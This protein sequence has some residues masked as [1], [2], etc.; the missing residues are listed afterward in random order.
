MSKALDPAV[1]DWA[2]Y[3]ERYRK[4]ELRA[5][6]FRDVIAADADQI[7]D[8]HGALTFLDIGCAA[9]RKGWPGTIMAVR[10]TK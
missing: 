2:V 9:F 4:G 1:I 3:I 6:V 7:A 8:R 10:V 5:G